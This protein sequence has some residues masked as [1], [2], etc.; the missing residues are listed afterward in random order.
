MFTKALLC[1]FKQ[2]EI[3]QQ[4]RI[5]T[6]VHPYDVIL[7]SHLKNEKAHMQKQ[8]KNSEDFLKENFK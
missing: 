4:Q 5:K 3:H 2:L 7:C 1:N 8:R 6:M